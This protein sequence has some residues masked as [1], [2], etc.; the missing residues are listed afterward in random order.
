VVKSEP[1]GKQQVL[2]LVEATHLCINCVT[3]AGL[4]AFIAAEHLGI[5][6]QLRNMRV[7]PFS[8]ST[9]TKS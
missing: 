8:R 9:A 1:P 6:N 5:D 2:D 7:K 3:P 4:P